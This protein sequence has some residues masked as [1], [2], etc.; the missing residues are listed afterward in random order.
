MERKYGLKN[1]P[2][3]P[4]DGSSYETRWTLDRPV[5]WSRSQRVNRITTRTSTSVFESYPGNSVETGFSI[6]SRP[7]VG[8]FIKL[9]HLGALLQSGPSICTQYHP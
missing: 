1:R 4:V 7:A 3:V 5:S 8:A 6:G 9:N 2:K